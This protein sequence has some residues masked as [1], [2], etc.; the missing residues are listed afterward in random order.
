MK[1]KKLATLLS[2]MIKIKIVEFEGIDISRFTEQLENVER[3]TF[4]NF[5]KAFHILK[6]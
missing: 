3:W 6:F 2:T 4:Q 5:M 1:M